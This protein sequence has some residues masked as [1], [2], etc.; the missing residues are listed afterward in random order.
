MRPPEASALGKMISTKDR[1]RNWTL[2]FSLE[3]PGII[4]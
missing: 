3:R 2:N 1:V 4:G